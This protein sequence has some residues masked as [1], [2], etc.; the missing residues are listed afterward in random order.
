MVFHH[1]IVPRYLCVCCVQ[2]IAISINGKQWN[3]DTYVTANSYECK[4]EELWK[5]ISSLR[6]SIGL[7]R[8]SAEVWKVYL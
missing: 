8:C 7:P 2:Y 1:M 3:P 4:D 5:N 6:V